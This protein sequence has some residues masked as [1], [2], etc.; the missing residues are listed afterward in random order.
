M[1]IQKLKVGMAGLGRVG[2]IHVNNF[3][4]QTPR[5]DLVAAFSPD[6]AEIA[7]GRQNLEPYGVTLYDDYDKM[8]AH[9]G[10]QAVVIGTAT[11]VH[12]EETMKAI[13][14]DLHVLCEKPLSTSVEVCKAVVQKA[15]TKP[16]L[17]VMC[18]FSRR[19]D[20]SYRE[21]HSKISQGLI[22]RPSIIR[23]QTCDKYDPSGFYVAYAAWSGGVF[24]DMS[25]HDIDLTLW[26]LGEDSIPKSISAYG[27]TAVQPELKQYNDYD[28]AVGIVEF[29]GGKIA[30]YYCSRMM[31]H[32]QEDTTEVIGTEGKLS[33]NINPQRDFVNYYHPGGITREVPP[34]FVGRFGE[35]FVREANEFTAACL[36]G[37]ALPVRLGNAVKAVEIGAY[38]QEALVSGRQ[39]RFDEIGRRVEAAQL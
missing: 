37:T 9:P 34:N 39:I 18:G 28:N 33:V 23:S 20:A 7:W 38:L 1:S 2:K 35:A 29:W 19:F 14:R 32:G 11:S 5:A 3:L 25:V 17:K 31:P 30:Y 36:E 8:L 22:G 16:H 4:H 26:F 6:P 15:Q 10:L 24:V 27:I 21:V 13:D 12:A